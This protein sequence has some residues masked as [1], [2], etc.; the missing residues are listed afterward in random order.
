MSD[1][2]DRCMI[3]VRAFFSNL[4]SLRKKVTAEIAI[5][6]TVDRGSRRYPSRLS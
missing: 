2:E 6:L 3:L 4:K 1:T 5:S